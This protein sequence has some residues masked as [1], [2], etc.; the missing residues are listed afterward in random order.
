MVEKL[1]QKQKELT[2]AVQQLNS[3]VQGLQ[4]EIVKRSE[5]LVAT[6]GALQVVTDLINEMSV[7]KEELK[8]DEQI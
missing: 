8:N 4:Q 6:K 1:E 7:K 2:T 3:Y 5:E